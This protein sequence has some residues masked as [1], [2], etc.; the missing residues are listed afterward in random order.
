MP[1]P[2]SKSAKTQS[3]NSSLQL[4]VFAFYVTVKML[5]FQKGRTARNRDLHILFVKSF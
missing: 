1:T 4:C 3:C 2:A 5:L